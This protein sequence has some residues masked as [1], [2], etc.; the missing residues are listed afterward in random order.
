MDIGA[1]EAA[2]PPQ[3]AQGGPHLRLFRVRSLWRGVASVDIVVYYGD[4]HTH[5][6]T[7]THTHTPPPSSSSLFI[8]AALM[9]M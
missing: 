2:P 3:A 9:L 8:M 6:D 7:E 5:T 1:G 4:T